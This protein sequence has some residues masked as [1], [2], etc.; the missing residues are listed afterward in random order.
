[1]IVMLQ[2]CNQVERTLV[3]KLVNDTRFSLH[4][5]E[6]I[7]FEIDIYIIKSN[8]KMKIQM[9]RVLRKR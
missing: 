9:K 2:K 3:V 7:K 1:M 8:T 5:L 4:G 6:S